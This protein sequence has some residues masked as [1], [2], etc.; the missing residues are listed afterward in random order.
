MIYFIGLTLIFLFIV[1]KTNLIKNEYLKTFLK[2]VVKSLALAVILEISFFNFRHY[3]SLFFKNYQEL[4]NYTIGEGLNCEDNKCS[5]TNPEEAY[6][7]FNNID[8][9]INN[10]Y[11]DI[12]SK[13]VLHLDYDII[14]DDEANKIPFNAGSRNY[15]SKVLNSH[16]NKINSSGTSNYLKI[17]FTKTNHKFTINKVSINKQVPLLINNLRLILVSLITLFI[18]LINS[19]NKLQDLKYNFSH[20]KLITWVIIISLSCFFGFLTFF[21]LRS[22]SVNKTS[23]YSQYKNLAHALA[24]GKVSLDLEVNPKLLALPNPYDT[25]YRDANVIRYQE[26]FWDYAFYNGKYYS[27]FGVVPCLLTYLPYYALTNED[28]PNPIAMSIAITIF[29]ISLFSLLYEV[30]KKYF[31]KTS[32]IYYILL[33]IFFI[34]ASNIATFTGEATFYSQPIIYAVAFTC[35]GLKFYIKATEKGKLNKTYLFLGSISMAL[36]AGCRPQLLLV[37]LL[38]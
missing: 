21:N 20:S 15:N 30:I 28:L 5:I 1:L 16:Y 7:E 6:I 17:Q 33:S 31:P 18:F 10:L 23:Q 8:N 24:K 3:E 4:T 11:L 32:Y 12:S 25:H 35:L 26:Y 27:Y 37:M 36:I 38:G 14:F 9:K 22:Y 19:Q 2:Y 29:I 13:G 34:M